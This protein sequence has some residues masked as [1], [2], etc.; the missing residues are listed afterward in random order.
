MQAK[1]K[2]HK[3]KEKNHKRR[4]TGDELSNICS[5]IARHSPFV[6]REDDAAPESTTNCRRLLASPPTVFLATTGGPTCDHLRPDAP[7]VLAMAGESVTR[8]WKC[9]LAIQNN[10][11]LQPYCEKRTS[12]TCIAYFL[13]VRDFFTWNMLVKLWAFRLL[14]WVISKWN[15]LWCCSPLFFTR[16]IPKGHYPKRTSCVFL[17][18]PQSTWSMTKST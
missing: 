14:D 3:N 6:A 16:A 8:K 15:N 9:L 12:N 13:V 10:H 17:S 4:D 5:R 2:N 18:S 7:H 1:T 11:S